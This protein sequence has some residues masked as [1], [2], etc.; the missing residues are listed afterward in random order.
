M[1]ITLNDNSIFVTRESPTISI[2]PK[3]RHELMRWDCPGRTHHQNAA[4]EAFRKTMLMDGQ[5]KEL[6]KLAAMVLKAEE[7]T[8]PADGEKQIFFRNLLSTISEPRTSILGR[9]LE[10]AHVL[11]IHHG[12]DA[13]IVMVD[14]GPES[15]NGWRAMVEE[16]VWWLYVGMASLVG[17]LFNLQPVSQAYTPD[18]LVSDCEKKKSKY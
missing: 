1:L 9:I 16:V 13:R 17:A 15:A 3:V 8:T 10:F 14:M 2:P 7:S 4:Q 11:I 5:S 12:L 6:E 18:S